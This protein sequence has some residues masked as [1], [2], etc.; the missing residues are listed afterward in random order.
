M[1][2]TPIEVTLRVARAIEEAGARY[3]LAGSLASSIYG[4]TRATLDVDLI[5]DLRPDQVARFVQA[6]GHDFYANEDSARRDAF[7][8]RHFNVI[9]MPSGFKADVYPVSG[10]LFGREELNRRR[11]EK[12]GSRPQD[13]AYLTTPEDLVVAKLRWFRAGGEVSDRQWADILGVLRV[14]EKN[15]DTPYMRRWAVHLHVED[16]LDRALRESA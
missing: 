2:E 10:D 4:Q 6:L 7:E 13:V 15:L 12:I 16:L 14:Q 9:H 8:G 1:D 3:A 11:A 5:T